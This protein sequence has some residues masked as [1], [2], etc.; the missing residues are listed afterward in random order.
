MN[1]SY[2]SEI[3]AD[4]DEYPEVTQDDMDRSVFVNLGKQPLH[5]RNIAVVQYSFAYKKAVLTHIKILKITVPEVFH[6][7]LGEGYFFHHVLAFTY[8]YGYF[9][10][11]SRKNQV[12]SKEAAILIMN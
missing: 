4:H 3:S 10:N 11:T 5:R 8:R 1:T 2:S 9:T 6:E 12:L 7:H